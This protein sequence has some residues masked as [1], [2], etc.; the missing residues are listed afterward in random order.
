M[1]SIQRIKKLLGKPNMPDQE[2]REVL[3]TLYGL[4]ELII[5]DLQYRQNS[6]PLQETGQNGV[7]NRE[8]PAK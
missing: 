5:E 2:A 1:I 6:G 4:A 3:N 7:E 8:L